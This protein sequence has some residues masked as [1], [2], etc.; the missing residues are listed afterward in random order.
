MCIKLDGKISIFK[1]TKD[2][3]REVRELTVIA[4]HQPG[5]L[6]W[7]GFFKKMMNS[8]IFIYF[9]DVKF[10]KN[11]FYNRN[12]IRTT[13][14]TTWL[15]IPVLSNN[16]N[17]NEVKI[18]NTKNWRK[19][20]KKSI[21]YNYSK[22]DFFEE[23]KNFFEQLYEKSFD[24]LIDINLEI[25]EFI[26][27]Q[28]GIN[29]KTAL[30]SE[31]GIYEEGSKKILEICNSLK[32]DSYISG[33]V[34][35]KDNLRLEDFKKNSIRVQFQEFQH[36][37]YKQFQGEFISRMSIIDLLFNEGKKEAMRILKNSTVKISDCVIE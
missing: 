21:L 30:S 10:V 31:F 13:N 20:H 32:A 34:W 35:A 5:Y 16:S 6:P 9:D 12:K 26:K 25:I 4:I 2:Q 11:N 1:N 33:T 29:T 27:N 14:G 24:L 22:S 23:N 15:T 3:S 7:L 8:D 17:I 36:P 18:D 37:V 19:K 28:L